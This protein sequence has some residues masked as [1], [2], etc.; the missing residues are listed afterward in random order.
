ME[1]VGDEVESILAI[2][3]AFM[4]SIG[5]PS[6][7]IHQ[8]QPDGVGHIVRV[9]NQDESRAFLL[10]IFEGKLVGASEV[11]AD[12]FSCGKKASH[13]EVPVGETVLGSASQTINEAPTQT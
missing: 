8:I 6:F 3:A 13:A 7:V 11:R 5:S 12:R 1:G 10:A 4:L 2:V 9:M